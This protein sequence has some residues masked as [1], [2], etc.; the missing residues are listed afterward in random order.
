MEVFIWT[1]AFNCGEILEPMLASYL[2]H[3]K[4]PVHVFGTEDDFKEI[5]TNSE[6]IIFESLDFNQKFKGNLEKRI[7]KGYKYGHKGTA[8]LWEH[9]INSRTEKIFIHLDSDN[10]FLGDSI[11]DLIYAIQK[12]GF[13]LAGSRRPYQTRHYRKNGKDG[14]KLDSRPDCVNTDCFAFTTDRIRKKPR[15]WLRRKILGRRTSLKPVIDAFDPISFEIIRKK[16]RVKYMDS[17]TDGQSSVANWNSKFLKQRISF[18]AVGSGCNFFKN[19]CVGIPDHYANY[20]LASY[21]LFAK[22]ILNKD[23]GIPPLENEG[24]MK[25][26]RFLDKSTWTI[27][28]NTLNLD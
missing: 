18:A 10:I 1:E 20:A 11:S 28:S 16:G 23:I 17:P 3:N 21:S 5:K 27:T 12:E 8:L 2:T 25:Q 7:I 6:L 4:Y 19:G 13:A 15:F 14:K 9:I 24:L 22:Q 26:L